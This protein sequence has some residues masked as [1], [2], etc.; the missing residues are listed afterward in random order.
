M[1][2]QHSGHP[3]LLWPDSGAVV[4]ALRS[5]SRPASGVTA[6]ACCR[7]HAAGARPVDQRAAHSSSIYGSSSRPVYDRPTVPD[8]PPEQPSDDRV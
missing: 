3:R 2:S 6:T 7:G 8:R 1:H 5:V 4:C